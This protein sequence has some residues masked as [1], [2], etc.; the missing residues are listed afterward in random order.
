M[1]E[2]REP[3][4]PILAGVKVIDLTWLISGPIACRFL[5]DHGA[6]VVKVETNRMPDNIRL[7]TPFSA[8]ISGV[9]RSTTFAN[10]NAG[11]YSISLNLNHPRA[12]EVARR[13]VSWAD[14]VVESFRPGLMAR[15]GLDY[16]HLKIIKPS[17]IMLSMSMQGQT[18][19]FARQPGVGTQLQALA[20]FTHLT[21]WPDREPV[22][23]PVPYPDFISPWYI[24]AG[25]MAALDYR[26]RTGNGIYMDMSQLETSLQLLGAPLMDFSANGLVLTRAGNKHRYAAPHGVYPCKGDDRWCAIAILDDRQWAGLCKT[27]GSPKWAADSRFSTFL[28]RK[29]NEA[30]LD[31]RIEAWTSARLAEDVS[32]Q[33]RAAGIPAGVVQNGRDLIEHDEQMRHRRHFQELLHPEIGRHLVEMPPYRISD[34]TGLSHRPAPCLGEHNHAVC[35]RVLGMTDEEFVDLLSEGVLE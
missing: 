10:Y 30:E 18:G 17:I 3:G 34:G 6:E 13:L 11:K 7:T 32:A 1:T 26:Q 12:S 21:G 29:E 20:G 5:G 8:N 27:M 19:P 14:V 31:A 9:N 25:I 33:L 23:L 35:T 24:V 28:G 4:V 15:W 16:S 2:G 22:G